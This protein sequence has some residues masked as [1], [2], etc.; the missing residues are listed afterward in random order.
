[1]WTF[2][3]ARTWW[4]FHLDPAPLLDTIR[5]SFGVRVVQNWAADPITSLTT[6]VVNSCVVSV[7]AIQPYSNSDFLARPSIRR[8][9]LVVAAKSAHDIGIVVLDAA[10][11]FV[12][13]VEVEEKTI[14]LE[15]A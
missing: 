15:E 2:A 14:V 1:M 3:F 8:T 7:A 12:G 4:C 6:L 9:S 11:R 5:N 10:P 13:F